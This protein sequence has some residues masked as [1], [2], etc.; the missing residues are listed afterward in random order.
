M[1]KSRLLVAAVLI[2]G[3]AFASTGCSSKDI[4]A[5]VNGEAITMDELNQ[6]VEQLKKSYPQMFD[7]PDGEGQLVTMKQRFLSQLIDQKLIAQA[8]KGRGVSVSDTEVKGQI[9]TLKAGFKDDAQFAQA[10]ESAG[11]DVNA[12]ES[13]IREQLLTQKLIESL[14]SDEEIDEAAV[15]EY[16]DNNKTQFL[17]KEAKRASHILFSPEDKEKADQVLKQLK[18]GSDFNSLAKAN[19]VDT[20][21]AEKGGDLGW[22]STP[23]VPE[24][25]AALDKLKVG[26]T[27]ELV[28]SPY[29]WH[30][31]RVTDE[32]KGSQ[33]TLEEVR[34]QIEQIIISQRRSEAYQKY[35]MQL[36][37]EAEI[38]IL[39]E[40]LREPEAP[41][42]PEPTDTDE[43]ADAEG[44]AAE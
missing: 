35:L 15:K 6:Q 22:P 44:D 43:P 7:G 39:V 3:L 24:F 18:D 31:I 26:Q 17:L 1:K 12:L 34:T 36:R 25:Q 10:L 32:R 28:Q 5:R 21:T 13:Q 42:A 9:D 16:Y 38:E 33:Q 2:L 40:E 11:L 14:A 37:E 8:A 30:I 20:V 27:S 23:Y 29:G 4:A 41:A 19:S